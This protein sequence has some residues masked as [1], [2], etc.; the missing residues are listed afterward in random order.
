MDLLDK[1]VVRLYR[2]DYDQKTI[3]SEDPL[4]L[5]RDFATAG[6]ERLHIVDLSGA[7]SGEP[8]Q[9]D[10][11][12]QIKEET[13]LIVEAGG[14]VRSHSTA[15]KYVEAEIDY[16]M[17]GSLPFQDEE[18]FHLILEKP[19][20]NKV[21]LTVDVMGY[22]VRIAGWREEAGIHMFDF[23]E[24]MVAA[25]ITQFL[26]TQIRQD[27]TLEGPDFELYYEVKRRYPELFVIASGGVSSYD[28][29]L[30]L[31]DN[32][33]SAAIIGKAFYEKRITMADM[34]KFAATNA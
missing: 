5:A 26:I 30:R 12:H 27:G 13:G 9:L 28:D 31:R 23:L 7:R 1:Q 2:G 25:G 29:L 16:I 15:L 14:G 18:Q 22:D 33:L 10:I 4:Q 32:G 19:G 34:E 20:V 11:I 3:Y 6:V 8:E 21:L 24:R 17:I